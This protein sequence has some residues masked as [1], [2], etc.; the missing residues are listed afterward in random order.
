MYDYYDYYD[1][2]PQMSTGSII[3]SLACSALMV[4]SLWFIF[5]KAG[6]PGWAAVVPFYNLYVLFDITWGNGVKFL[7]LLIPFANVVFLILTYVKLAKSFGMSG[8]F[9]VGLVLVSVVFFPLLAFG[10]AQYLGVP[11]SGQSGYQQG[12]YQQPNQGY[13]QGGYQQSNQSYQ[14]P[15][16]SY[17]SPQ[18]PSGQSKPA[19]CPNCGSPVTPG[20]GFCSNCGQRL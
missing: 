11:P 1:Y 8:G 6:R 15:E 20:S 7:F 17:Q 16:Q 4:V 14:Q 5:K 13:Q 3:I 9:A 10:G 12:G 2:Y 18:Q 19:F